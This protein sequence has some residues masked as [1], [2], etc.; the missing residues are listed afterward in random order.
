MVTN[1]WTTGGRGE[2]LLTGLYSRG[3]GVPV[4]DPRTG[5]VYVFES[6][7]VECYDPSKREWVAL[8]GAPASG[9]STEPTVMAHYSRN[10]PTLIWSNILEGILIIGQCSGLHQHGSNANR[11]IELYRPDDNTFTLLTA[12]CIP[13]PHD[14]NDHKRHIK[15]EVRDD[16]LSVDHKTGIVTYNK[17]WSLPISGGD[18][19]HIIDDRYLVYTRAKPINDEDLSD[20]YTLPSLGYVT[21]L[22]AHPL[23]LPGSSGSGASEATTTAVVAEPAADD[24]LANMGSFIESEAVVPPQRIASSGRLVW[25]PLPSLPSLPS[26]ASVTPTAAVAAAAMAPIA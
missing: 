18:S 13:V 23:V 20:H 11:S 8:P 9:S 2:T 3:Q 19:L 7:R 12:P 14:P 21:D 1:E 22:L 17:G 26:A 5:L 4:V 10:L 15:G 6:Q 25:Y 24:F 16:G